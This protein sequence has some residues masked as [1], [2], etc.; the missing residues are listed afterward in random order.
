M[1]GSGND[2]R[3]VIEARIVI[4]VNLNDIDVIFSWHDA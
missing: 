4:D 3:L 1:S 2:K